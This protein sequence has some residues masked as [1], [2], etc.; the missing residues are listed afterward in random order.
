VRAILPPEADFWT[1]RALAPRRLFRTSGD[2][3]FRGLPLKLFG[4]LYEL[5]S[6]WIVPRQALRQPQAGFGFI[7]EI[8][9]VHRCIPLRTT[10]RPHSIVCR[11]SGSTPSAVTGITDCRSCMVTRSEYR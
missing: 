8:D 9:R 6:R 1:E 5:S 4:K 10:L 11:V 2:F 3:E 7:P